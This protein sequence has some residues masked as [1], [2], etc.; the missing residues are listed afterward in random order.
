MPFW[1]I[2]DFSEID[3]SFI[4]KLGKRIT[5]NL[6]FYQLDFVTPGNKPSWAISRK[7]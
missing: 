3:Y 1:D 5:K 4:N 2:I 7:T 6:V